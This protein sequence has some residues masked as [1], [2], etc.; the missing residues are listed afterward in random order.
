M[1][2]EILAIIRNMALVMKFAKDEYLHLIKTSII[3]F[4]HKEYLVFEFSAT[5]IYAKKTVKPSASTAKTILQ[6]QLKPCL[7]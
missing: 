5:K 6:P 2:T 7:A 4:G 1:E 3:E